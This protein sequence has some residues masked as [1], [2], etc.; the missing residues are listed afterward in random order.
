MPKTEKRAYAVVRS[1]GALLVEQ[2][3]LAAA[4]FAPGDPVEI[5]PRVDERLLPNL[6]LLPY[7]GVCGDLWNNHTDAEQNA[8]SDAA[9]ASEKPAEIRPRVA[10]GE[11]GTLEAAALIADAHGWTSLA[12]MIRALAVPSG[13]PQALPEEVVCEI[14]KTPHAGRHMDGLY[15]CVDPRPAHPPSSPSGT[16]H[17]TPAEPEK[18]GEVEALRAENARLRGSVAQFDTIVEHLIVQLRDAAKNLD[19]YL[20]GYARDY[21]AQ[22]DGFTVARR[23]ALPPAASPTSHSAPSAGP[24]TVATKGDK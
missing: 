8:C 14:E 19:G 17:A 9:P 5:R 1:Y 15:P 24:S 11:S 12:S 13:K 6:E 2:P 23:V 20:P 4:G 18:L 7:C 3:A 16:S 21:R 10:P 22:A